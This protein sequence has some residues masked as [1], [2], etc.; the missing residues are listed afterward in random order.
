MSSDDEEEECERDAGS[1]SKSSVL[2]SR[3]INKY[4][5]AFRDLIGEKMLTSPY[6]LI[7]G[8]GTTVEIDESMFGKREFLNHDLC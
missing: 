2:S 5:S 3:T 6:T 1:S 7:G 8:P 4:Y